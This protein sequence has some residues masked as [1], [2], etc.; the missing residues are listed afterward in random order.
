MGALFEALKG[1]MTRPAHAEV[2]AGHDFN[3]RISLVHIFSFNSPRGG[4]VSKRMR[5]YCD[6]GNLAWVFVCLVCT[7]GDHGL[8]QEELRRVCCCAAHISDVR[9]KYIIVCTT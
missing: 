4:V 1:A 7:E 5:F 3:N 9:I 6:A 2:Q 8:V